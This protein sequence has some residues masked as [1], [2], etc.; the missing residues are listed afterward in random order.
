MSRMSLYHATI[1]LTG[2]SDEEAPLVEAYMRES[3]GTLSN[4]S[5]SVFQREALRCL[6]LV[7]ADPQTARML[8]ESYGLVKP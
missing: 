1:L 2:C 8:A 7:R 5:G 6:A 4:L 3:Y